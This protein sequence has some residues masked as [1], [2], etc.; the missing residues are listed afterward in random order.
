MTDLTQTEIMDMGAGPKINA[1][2]ATEVMGWEKY[3]PEAGA[4][5]WQTKCETGWQYHEVQKSLLWSPSTHIESA[6]EVW[7][8]FVPDWN[9]CMIEQHLKGWQVWLSKDGHP[10][11]LGYNDVPTAIAPTAPLAICRTALLA[12]IRSVT[13]DHAT[14]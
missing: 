8:I 11:W 14:E 10:S 5:F 7:A 2:I 3:N 6:M 13:D 4:A 1:L 9:P 12:A